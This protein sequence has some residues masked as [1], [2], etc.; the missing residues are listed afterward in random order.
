MGERMSES[1]G[2]TKVSAVS[3]SLSVAGTPAQAR[4]CAGCCYSLAGIAT[5]HAVATTCP[6]CGVRSSPRALTRPL[7]NRQAFV[8]MCC[9][10]LAASLLAL[11]LLAIPVTRLATALMLTVAGTY[12]LAMVAIPLLVLIFGPP[13]TTALRLQEQLKVGHRPTPSPGWTAIGG[14]LANLL[15]VLCVVLAVLLVGR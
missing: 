1:S 11:A 2:P 14:G 9:P 3:G 7:T 12:G 8:A 4:Y 5:D 6:E 15:L 13:V 10:T